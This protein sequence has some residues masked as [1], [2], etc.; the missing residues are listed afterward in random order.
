MVPG[1]TVRV[2]KA[3]TFVIVE[4]GSESEGK[5]EDDGKCSQI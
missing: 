3:A 4:F 5:D 1:E 2:Q